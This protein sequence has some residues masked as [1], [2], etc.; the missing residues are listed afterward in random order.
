MVYLATLTTVLS[1]AM[2]AAVFLILHARKRAR[3]RDAQGMEHDLK[4][5]TARRLG[6]RTMADVGTMPWP[7]SR[8]YRASTSVNPHTIVPPPGGTGVQDGPVLPEPGTFRCPI[9]RGGW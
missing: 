1:A 3:V 8:G 7:P 9:T 6:L 2:S 5:S 4:V